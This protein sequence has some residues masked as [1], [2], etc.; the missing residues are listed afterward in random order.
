[1]LLFSLPVCVSLYLYPFTLISKSM[2]L[3]SLD[4]NY[5][6]Y[7]LDNKRILFSILSCVSHPWGKRKRWAMVRVSLWTSLARV[8]S[9]VRLKGYKWFSVRHATFQTCY[10]ITLSVQAVRSI[11]N[12]KNPIFNLNDTKGKVGKRAFLWQDLEYLQLFS[13]RFLLKSKLI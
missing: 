13:Q 3:A 6:F 11:F 8:V 12:K 7:F 5:W 10:W 2:I 1:M 9:R 4:L